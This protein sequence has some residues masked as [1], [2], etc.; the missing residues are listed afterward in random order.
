M[1][2][3][4]SASLRLS[5]CWLSHHHTTAHGGAIFMNENT[6]L[7]AINC[8]LDNATAGEKGGGLHM[9]T[10]CS[11]C[12]VALVGS[13]LLNTHARVGG[14]MWVGAGVVTLDNTTFV[15]NQ[16]DVNGGALLVSGEARV[17]MTRCR[18]QGCNALIRHGGGLLARAKFT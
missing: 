6:S 10:S 18:V 11:G 13:R 9:E 17:R 14:G 5:A 4:N 1:Y 15:N 16:A 7:S 3:H 12:A 8:T 2:L